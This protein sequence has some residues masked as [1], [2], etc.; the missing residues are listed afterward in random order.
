[1]AAMLYMRGAE[2]DD[3]FRGKAARRRIGDEFEAKGWRSNKKGSRGNKLA[4]LRSRGEGYYDGSDI[5]GSTPLDLDNSNIYPEWLKSDQR[6]FHFTCPHCSRFQ[7]LV[8]GSR[9]EGR[10]QLMNVRRPGEA[11]GEPWLKP[12]LPALLDVRKY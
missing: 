10:G 7:P 4:L 12:V 2:N 1:N 6:L 9:K 8:W 5:I 3:N 11:R